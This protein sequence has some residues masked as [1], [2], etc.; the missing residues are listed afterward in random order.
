MKKKYICNM[1][2][3]EKSDKDSVCLNCGKQLF[4]SANVGYG[5]V[6][7]S[8]VKIFPCVLFITDKRFIIVSDD[9]TDGMFG[10]AGAVAS[11][12]FKPK[13]QQASARYA[14]LSDIEN[15]VYPIEK[16]GTVFN[17]V[18]GDKGIRI[19]YANGVKIVLRLPNAKKASEIVN[20]LGTLIKK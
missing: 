5:F 12:L 1:C 7:E 14:L 4:S 19:D 18:K 17:G 9:M 6:T 3:A 13:D 11:E 2:G 10:L 8:T 16:Y 15:V 20:L